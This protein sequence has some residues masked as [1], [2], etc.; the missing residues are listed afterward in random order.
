ME[1]KTRNGKLYLGSA[2]RLIVTGWMIGFGVVVGGMFLLI[3]LLTLLF[4]GTTTVNGE[5]VEGTGPLLAAL[6]MGLI[7]V[8]VIIIAHAFMF[9]GIILLGLLIYRSRKPIRVVSDDDP[10]QVPDET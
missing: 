7:M 3:M 9:G 5:V 6:G 4:G 1:L 10:R 2:Y 8:P